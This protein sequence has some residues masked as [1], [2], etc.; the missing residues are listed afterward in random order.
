MLDL[1]LDN[2]FNERIVAG[3]LAR[4]PRLDVVRLREIGLDQAPDPQVLAYAADHERVVVTHDVNT[5]T[6]HA[7]RRVA[8]GLKMPGMLVM[9]QTIDIGVGVHAL[10]VTAA[11]LNVGELEGQVW[12]LPF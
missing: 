4:E 9:H 8:D 1:L 2:D 7:Y 10:L 5:M 3:V 12:F 11:C 6:A